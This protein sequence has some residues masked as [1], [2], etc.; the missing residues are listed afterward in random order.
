M[1]WHQ[2]NPD[3]I[4]DAALSQAAYSGTQEVHGWQKD[5]ELS[6]ENRVVYHKEGKAKIAFRGTNP[7]NMKDLGTDLLVGLGL[8]DQSSRFK[9][10]VKTTDLA[11]KKY[12]KEN[13]SLTGHS[14]G[15]SQ[16]AYVSRKRGLKATGFNAAWSRIDEVRN[17]TYS[18]FHAI[19][20]KSD[21]IGGGARFIKKVGKKT[22]VNSKSWNPHGLSKNFV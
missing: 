22:W 2:G 21:P 17:R 18:H 3:I 10:A 8:Q 4:H 5:L 19:Q 9:N 6:N 7:R 14:L 11:I 1:D 20:T 16:S 15:G 12:G 13:V